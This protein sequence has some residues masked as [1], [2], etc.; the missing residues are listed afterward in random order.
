MNH[1]RE[2]AAACIILALFLSEIPRRELLLS[3]G[4]PRSEWE[5]LIDEWI[6]SERSRKILRRWLLDGITF[7]QLAEE[8]ELSVRRTKDIVLDAYNT[9]LPA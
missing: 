7:E 5:R 9:L 1:T 4:L 6:F 2:V 3:A 8:F